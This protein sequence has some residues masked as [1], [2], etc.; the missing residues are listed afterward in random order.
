VVTQWRRA[1][2]SL[3]LT[4]PLH[5]LLVN[6][7]TFAVVVSGKCLFVLVAWPVMLRFVLSPVLLRVGLCVCWSVCWYWCPLVF[8]A[9]SVLDEASVPCLCWICSNIGSV[10]NLAWFWNSWSICGYW[11]RPSLLILLFLINDWL[12]VSFLLMALVILLSCCCYF[13][14]CLRR[15]WAVPWLLDIPFPCFDWW[16]AIEL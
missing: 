13:S 12:L 1:R 11:Y 9:A 5:I 3:I 16:W 10:V 14:Y 15:L 7:E 6:T 8:M 2:P 4:L